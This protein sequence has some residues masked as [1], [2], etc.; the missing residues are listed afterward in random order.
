MRSGGSNISGYNERYDANANAN[1]EVM[2]WPVAARD[3]ASRI[4]VWVKTLVGR[5]RQVRTVNGLNRYLFRNDHISKRP[6][7][8]LLLVHLPSSNCQSATSQVFPRRCEQPRR[9]SRSGIRNLHKR[10]SANQV[11]YNI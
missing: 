7:H 5:A 1:I 10:G 4:K 2:L 6:Y 11:Y 9:D 8:V 3:V